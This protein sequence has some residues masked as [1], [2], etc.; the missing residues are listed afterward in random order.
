MRPRPSSGRRALSAIQLAVSVALLAWAVSR[1]DVAAT[2]SLLG[3]V[4]VPTWIV[5]ALLTSVGPF[6]AAARVRALFLAA[7]RPVSL[8]S[9]IALNLESMFFTLV[10]PGDL[11]GGVVRW[12]RIRT[13]LGSGGSALG[14]VLV[15]RFIDWIGLGALACVG[16]ALLFEG[17]HALTLQWIVGG[18]GALL[19]L[20]AAGCLVAAR[21]RRLAAWAG[22]LAARETPGIRGRAAR[23]AEAAR[24]AVALA[25]RD[26]R[27]V[28]YLTGLTVVLWSV[29]WMGYVV[30]ARAVHPGI[31]AFALLG[32]AATVALLA[33]LPLTI[34]GLGLREASLPVLLAAYGVDREVGLLLGLSLFLPGFVLG[35]VGGLLHLM[36]RTRLPAA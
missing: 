14:F 7:G 34:A 36:G 16:A 23:G 30:L 24:A 11:A 21:S 2:A 25:T 31:P 22:R 6:V 26:R 35:L 27:L 8:A 4:D 10:L 1:V 33:Q 29:S 15:E 19:V 20:A 18:S 3:E 5:G 9:V 13:G 32:A 12:S 17:E 28:V